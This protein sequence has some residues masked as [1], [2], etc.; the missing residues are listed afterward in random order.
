V[1]PIRAMPRWPSRV[2]IE[3]E[4]SAPAPAQYCS[5]GIKKPEFLD[6]EGGFYASEVAGDSKEDFLE[7]LRR[8]AARER[9]FIEAYQ[10]NEGEKRKERMGGGGSDGAPAGDVPLSEVPRHDL[11]SPL[12]DRCNCV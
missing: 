4:E 3:G 1:D 11:N 6:E 5:E 10:G 8:D 2:R 12:H 7:N 9:E